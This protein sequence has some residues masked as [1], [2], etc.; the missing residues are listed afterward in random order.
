MWIKVPPLPASTTCELW[1]LKN[2]G[3][4]PDLDKVMGYDDSSAYSNA[5]LAEAELRKMFL[6]DRITVSVEVICMELGSY[7]VHITNNGDKKFTGHQVPIPVRELDITY[8]DE[9]LVV[10]E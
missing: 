10:L 3:Y 6:S 1:I 8:V 7:R 9:S 5:Y 4:H 2:D